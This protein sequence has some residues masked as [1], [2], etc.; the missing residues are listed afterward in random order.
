M[1]PLL[2]GRENECAALRARLADTARVILVS[3]EAGVGKTTLVEHVLVGTRTWRGRADEWAGAAYDIVASALRSVPGWELGADPL[4]QIRPGHAPQEPSALAAA[5][6][7]A[8]ASAAGGKPAVLFLDDLQWADEASLDLLP[9]L[10]EACSSSRIAVA[11]CYRSDELPRDHRLRVV[12]ALLRR[13]RQLAEIALGRLPDP[14]VR[15]MLAGL[16]AADPEPALVTTVADRA[17]GLPF[18]VEELAFALR[19]GGHLAYRDGTVALADASVTG[20]VAVPDGIRDTVLL[21]TSRLSAKERALI[22]AAAVAGNEFEVDTVLAATG[23][24]AQVAAE[25]DRHE[26]P[27]AWPDGFTGRG[28]LSEVADGRAAFRHPLSRE[29]AYADIP[30]PR[31]R[32]LHRALAGALAAGGAPPALIAA[33]LLAARDFA[34]ARPALV[35]AADQHCAVHA[36]RDAARALR[37]ALEHW[38]VGTSPDR[39]AV[40]DRLARCAEMSSEY[41]EAIALLGELADGHEQNGDIRALAATRRRLALAAELRGDWEAALAT[42]EAAATAYSAAGLPAEA[43]IDRIAVA[44]HQ[45]SA[46]SF[47][48]ALATLTAA[49]SDATASGRLD[50]L[51]RAEGL[52]G[53]VLARFG[54]AAEGMSVLRAALD[55]ALAASLTDTAAELQQRLADSLEHA[56]DYGAAAAAYA[57]AY[58]YCDAHGADLIGQLCRACA[59]AVLFVK[60]EWDRAI[61]VCEDVLGSPAPPHARAVSTGM[62]GLVHALRG[63]SAR[64]RPFLVES[65]VIA[66]RIELTAMELISSWGLCLLADAAGAPDAAAERGRQLLARLARTQER[67]Y[68]VA[69]LQWAATFFSQQGHVGDVG[70]CAAALSGIAE[71]TAQPE[72]IA[73]LAH[74]RGEIM[75]AD[76]PRTAARELDRAAEIFGELGLPL[77]TALAQSRAAVAAT[78]FGEHGRARDLLRAAHATAARLGARQLR[79]SCAAALG[80]GRQRRRRPVTAVGLTA[81]ELEVMRLVAG[82]Q[83]S[84]QIAGILFISPRTVEMHVQ[85][86]ML[87]LACRTRAQ[88]TRRLAE[89]G[90]LGPI[91]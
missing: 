42:R 19:D 70:A 28:L 49:E 24:A 55:Q 79:E 69:I 86:S 47:S 23:V 85:G 46:A 30:W 26:V 62:A 90:A 58:Q 77:A 44:V 89:L 60:G 88:A 14:Y 73:A 22:E 31:R 10:A 68:S 78:R 34:Q 32:R 64:A 13:K 36:Y 12:R 8:L 84:R 11:G 37:T 61:G 48:A 82:G 7:S 80:L 1:N 91:P 54:R 18:A 25:N 16:L 59:T 43:A 6:S 29:A 4:T 2:I 76:E 81:R 56:G 51:L 33:H 39:L 66:A 38:G 57:S 20:L 15:R 74:A 41:A 9:A 45:R 65:N 40:I 17:Q 71:A 75:L 5:V 63:N 53:N 50:L 87:K 52:R 72:A 83:T 35:A 67:H 27:R 3:G 21:R